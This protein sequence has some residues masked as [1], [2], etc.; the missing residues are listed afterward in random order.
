AALMAMPDGGAVT[1][2]IFTSSRSRVNPDSVQVTAPSELVSQ[3]ALA[4][5]ASMAS[6]AKVIGVSA[7]AESAREPANAMLPPSEVLPSITARSRLPAIKDVCLWQLL[8]TDNSCPFVT[9][10]APP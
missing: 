5:E 10:T 2:W 9:T 4:G 6:E 8:A 7:S 3:S 1:V